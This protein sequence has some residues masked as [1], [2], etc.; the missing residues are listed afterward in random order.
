MKKV[1]SE[2]D[3][4]KEQE[5]L[6]KKKDLSFFLTGPSYPTCHINALAAANHS[7]TSPV[8]MAYSVLGFISVTKFMIGRCVLQFHFQIFK[9]PNPNYLPSLPLLSGPTYVEA[10]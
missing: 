3:G 8:Y 4:L 10:R 9:N 7:A 1:R 6:A 2:M 5:I